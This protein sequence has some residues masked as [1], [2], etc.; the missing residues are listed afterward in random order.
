MHYFI[1]VRTVSGAEYFGKSV[2]LTEA[3]KEEVL[4]TTKNFNDLNVFQ[5]EDTNNSVISF[6]LSH[7]ESISLETI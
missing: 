2:E 6:N 1:K 7:V 3:E 5:L 4:H